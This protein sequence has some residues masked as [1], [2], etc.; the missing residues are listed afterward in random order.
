M[1]YDHWNV[2][3]RDVIENLAELPLLESTGQEK[4]IYDADG[5]KI[6]RRR[7]EP[8]PPGEDQMWAGLLMNVKTIDSLF[9]RKEVTTRG[10]DSDDS[11]DELAAVEK[12]CTDPELGIYPQAFTNQWGHFQAN[13]LMHHFD[14]PIKVINNLY[15]CND[16]GQRGN[17]ILI[18][19]DSCQ[20]Y[21]E[22]SHR[23][24]PRAGGQDVQKGLITAAIMRG[25]GLTAAEKTKTE[26]WRSSCIGSLPHARMRQKIILPDC[27]KG[28][29][30][31]HVYNLDLW[32][33]PE[34]E[35]TGRYVFY[36][37]IACMAW[38]G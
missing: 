26:K 9:L 2:E 29:R 31:E 30:L 25:A 28:F 23:T 4:R 13:C 37:L 1:I 11:E 20:G 8:T 7:A 38:S 32:A 18:T 24:A 14:A 3:L 33:V 19:P 6:S 27:P 5:A 35:R 15:I 36:L 16:I 34:G 10:N 21:N 12:A 22:L 17:T